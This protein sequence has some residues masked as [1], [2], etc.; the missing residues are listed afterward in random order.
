MAATLYLALKYINHD[1]RLDPAIRA[2]A[3]AG[4]AIATPS[5]IVFAYFG[6]SDTRTVASGAIPGVL[7]RAH[8]HGVSLAVAW[9]LE[10]ETPERATTFHF[11]CYCAHVAVI[12][13]IY[14]AHLGFIKDVKIYKSTLPGST[15]ASGPCR[16]LFC[17]LRRATPTYL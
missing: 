5:G 3:S 8:I 17:S 2:T 16:R 15:E 14:A 11:R 12:G 13:A 1:A 7:C 6:P 4:W 9:E 10:G